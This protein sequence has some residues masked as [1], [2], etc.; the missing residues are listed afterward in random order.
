M[1]FVRRRSLGIILLACGVAVRANAPVERIIHV[2][3]PLR[4]LTQC[5]FRELHNTELTCTLDGWQHSIALDPKTQLWKGRVYPSLT[6]LRPGDLLDIKLGLDSNSREVAIFVWANLVQVE[7]VLGRAS[8]RWFPVQP[9]IPHTVGEL[10]DRR[11]FAWVD[12]ETAIVGG[13]SQR[14]LQEGRAVIVIGER[15]DNRRIR[16]TRIALSTW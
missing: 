4:L 14:E 7:G 11:I 12:N 5:E 2:D 9:L 15:L 3:P 13:A 6:A 16:A 1:R 10:S 8:E